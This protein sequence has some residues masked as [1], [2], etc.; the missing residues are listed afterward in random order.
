VSIVEHGLGLNITLQSYAGS[1]DFGILAARV[2]MPDA[3]PL[4]RGL[5]EALAELARATDASAVAVEHPSDRPPLEPAKRA[6][7]SATGS[8]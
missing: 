6:R 8:Q 4:A 2:G 1:L 3:R 5:H 7:R